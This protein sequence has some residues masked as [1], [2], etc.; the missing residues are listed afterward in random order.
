[1]TGHFK[2]PERAVDLGGVMREINDTL[3]EDAER[4]LRQAQANAPR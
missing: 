1:L 4:R 3:A 2:A